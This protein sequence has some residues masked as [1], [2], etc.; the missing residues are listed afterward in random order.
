MRFFLCGCFMLSLVYLFA[1][2][3]NIETNT[4]DTLKLHSP[5]KAVVFSA[6][7]PGAG[8]VYNHI[9]MPKGKKKAFWKVPLIYAGLGATGYFLV[10]NQLTQKALKTDYTNRQNGGLPDVRWEQYDNEGILTLYNQYLNKRDLSILGVG[11]VYLFQLVDAGIEAHFVS[12]D[13]SEDLS[14]SLR[15]TLL[16]PNTAGVALRLNFH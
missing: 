9:A 16:S 5:K 10:S 11:A 3:Q 1:Q 6:I 7:L 13:V 2:E 15:P 12:F 14:M 4:S 8:Q